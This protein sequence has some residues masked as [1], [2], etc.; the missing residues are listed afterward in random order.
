[1]LAHV[2]GELEQSTLCLGA[3]VIAETYTRG[4]RLH[5]GCRV[6]HNVLD[7]KIGHVL[8]DAALPERAPWVQ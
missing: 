8:C 5:L 3:H 6:E 7:H 2:Y 4:R 1:M